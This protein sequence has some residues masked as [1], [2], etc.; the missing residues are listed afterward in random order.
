MSTEGESAFDEEAVCWMG[1]FAE[2]CNCP[3]VRTCLV[4]R[5]REGSRS[6]YLLLP[7][8]KLWR[9][10]VVVTVH[11]ASLTIVQLALGLLSCSIRTNEVCAHVELVCLCV[12]AIRFISG[13]AFEGS[14][15]ADPDM[16]SE[17]R[18]EG[19]TDGGTEGVGG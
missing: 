17:G 2:S 10:V 18:K 13:G 5:H 6:V 8:T 12:P 15:I 16:V 9:A 19:R 1:W 14:S 3:C 4:G 7:F 11:L